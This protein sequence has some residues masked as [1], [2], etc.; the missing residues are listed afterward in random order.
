MFAQGP[1]ACTISLNTH[2]IVLFANKYDESQVMTLGKQLYPKNVKGFLEAY[3][4]AT[5]QPFGYLV[6]DCNPKSP[7][8]KVAY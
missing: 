5:A 6:I 3:E 1:N 4:D 7:V 8:F 2:V